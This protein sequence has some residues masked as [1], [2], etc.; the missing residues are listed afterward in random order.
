MDQSHPNITPRLVEALYVEA[1]L[2][3]DEARSYFEIDASAGRPDMDPRVAV[4]FSCESLKVTTRLMHCIAWLL[5]QKAVHNGELSLE[6]ARQMDRGLG[7]APKS[8]TRLADQFPQQALDLISLSEDLF[9][10]V[11]RL[12]AQL[13]ERSQR[14]MAIHDMMER[15]QQ[16][17]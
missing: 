11:R 12:S 4:A 10:R 16:S 5:N 1:M 6:Q 3:A 9:E 17:L 14:N 2:L 15:L 13:D 8:D 7:Y